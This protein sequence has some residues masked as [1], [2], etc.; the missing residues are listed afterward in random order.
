M[1]GEK[2]GWRITLPGKSIPMPGMLAYSSH[3]EELAMTEFVEVKNQI[4][5]VTLAEELNYARASEKLNITQPELKR[6]ITELENQLAL[7]VFRVSGEDAEVTEAGQVLVDAFRTVL[8][9]RS[10]QGAKNKIQD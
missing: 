4:A 10:G 5:V 8:A 9:T 3:D 1:E 7:Q 2:R 6:Q